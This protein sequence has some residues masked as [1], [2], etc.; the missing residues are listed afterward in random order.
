MYCPEWYR[1]VVTKIDASE[2]TFDVQY[3]DGEEDKGLKGYCIR[4]FVPYVLYEP[5]G[6]YVDDEFYNGRIISV[7][8]NFRYDVETYTM[9]VQTGVIDSH[10]RRFDYDFRLGTVVEARNGD[11]RWRRGKVDA[12]QEVS[13]DIV[14]DSGE[15]EFEV[16]IS[17]FRLIE[18]ADETVGQEDKSRQTFASGFLHFNV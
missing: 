5:V 3:D 12:L 7:H 15:K 13:I 2:G 16:P 9:G 8:D 18:V 4:P 14:Y 11:G 1:G 10:L 17:R 6:V